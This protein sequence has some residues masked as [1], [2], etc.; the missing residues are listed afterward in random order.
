MA[1]VVRPSISRSRA[2]LDQPLADRVEGRRRLVEDQDAGV[3]EQDPGDRDPLLLAARQLVAALA[4]H[5]V[6]AVG[7]LGDPIVDRR[8]ARGRDQ[9]VVGRLGPGVA[10]V[11]ADRRVEQVRLLGHEADR[12]AQRGEGDPADVDDRRS[13]PSP[14]STSY[15]RGIR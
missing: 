9:L 10:Q 3:L 5:R 2:R 1:I 11:V 14:Q 6:V 12:L 4:D 13:R 8:R 7:Q 15:S